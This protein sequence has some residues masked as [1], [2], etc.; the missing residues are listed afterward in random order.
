VIVA[1]EAVI[2]IER[3][4]QQ[5]HQEVRQCLPILFRIVA[6]RYTTL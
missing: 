3:H 4:D 6:F 5:G 2:F 1:F